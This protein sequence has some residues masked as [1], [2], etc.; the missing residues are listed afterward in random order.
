MKNLTAPIRALLPVRRWN[1]NAFLS[2]CES[3]EAPI[4]WAVRSNLNNN[5]YLILLNKTFEE[6]LRSFL[7]AMIYKYIYIVAEEFGEAVHAGVRLGEK[8]FCLFGF[9]FNTS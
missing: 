4:L 8:C 2:F 9:F 1:L 6:E 5:R 3:T 7:L